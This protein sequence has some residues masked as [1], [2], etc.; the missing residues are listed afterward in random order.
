MKRDKEEANNS[1][2]RMY[3]NRTAPKVRRFREGTLLVS[4][5]EFGT[6]MVGLALEARQIDDN[7]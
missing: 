4:S 5:L 2:G 3:R 6:K 7:E 1:P